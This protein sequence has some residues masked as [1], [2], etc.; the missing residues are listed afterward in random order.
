[1]LNTSKDINI[2]AAAKRRAVIG[3]AV[4]LR[5]LTSTRRLRLCLK[6]LRG[7]G[8][9]AP[10]AQSCGRLIA[11]SDGLD[12]WRGGKATTLWRGAP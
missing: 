10:T 9:T 2:A 7:D 5:A 4:V 11:R 1:M 8:K 3:I 12:N 6:W